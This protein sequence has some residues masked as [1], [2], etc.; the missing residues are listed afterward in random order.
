MENSA[1]NLEDV[2]VK[3]LIEG[4][5]QYYGYDFRNYSFSSVKRRTLRF[6]Q[7]EEV[8][9]VSALQ[10][11][12]LRDR[13]CLDRFIANLAVHV[14]EMFRDPSF[15]I[16]FRQHVVPLLRTYPFIRIWHAGCST[17]EEV[18]SM[19]ILLAEEG[20]LSRCRI[21]ATDQSDR[22]L[23]QAKAGI[24]P[25]RLM[26]EYTQ[27]YLKSGGTCSFSEYYTATQDGALFRAE[28]RQNLVFA[29]HNLT[30]DQSFNEFN[31]ILCRNVLIYFNRQLQHQV[32][33]LFYNS[34][35]SL[36]I[37]GLGRHES[38]KFTPYAKYYE[39]LVPSE[40]L[41]RRLN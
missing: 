5:H 38:L 18:Y 28:L 40:K 25:L 23:Q 41:Y 24:Y 11:K 27:N 7:I 17:G 30:V 3:L 21:Y 32:H 12:I 29:Q 36:G 1:P 2:E 31:V 15:F 14:T 19:A 9:T 16:A 33:E 39:M 4:I 22:V 26:Q 34:L 10:E 20:L 13:S 37:L 35:C 6:L 8:A